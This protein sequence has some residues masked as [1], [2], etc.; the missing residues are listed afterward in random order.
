VSTPVDRRVR[1]AKD[2]EAVITEL[3]TDGVF[4]TIRE[5]L[6]FAAALGYQRG[7]RRPITEASEPVRWDTMIKSPYLEAIVDM[8][9][10]ADGEAKPELLADSHL[11]ERLK[12]FEEFANGGLEILQKE[13]R[14]AYG[15]PLDVIAEIVGKALRDEPQTDRL[16]VKELADELLW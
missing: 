10:A 15:K 6:V 11:D 13:L 2:K 9:C 7:I 5:V 8:I 1:R 16:S 3:T 12:T 4:T 14:T